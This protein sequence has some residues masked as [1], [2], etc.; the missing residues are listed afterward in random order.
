MLADQ[1]PALVY[2]ASLPAR[3]GQRTQAQ[4]LRVVAGIL[5]KGSQDVDRV[6]WGAL[7]YQHTTLI[8]SKLIEADAP[9]TANKI[10]SALRGTLKEAWRLGL[11]TAEEYQRARDLNPIT[12]VTLPA[13][14]ELSQGEI[15][16]LMTA[17]GND[18]SPAGTRDAAIIALLYG[19]GLRRDEVI[20]LDF[21][22]YDK[23]SG[24]LVV[25]GKRSKE[26]TA[27]LVN[28]AA[29][30]MADWLSLRGSS[31]GAL[32]LA[33]NK[34]G[35]VH[36]AR[37]TSQA[38]YNMLV[39]RA[40]EANVKEFSPHDFRRTF[41]SDLLDK[42]A[43]IATVSKMAGHSDPKTTARYD[44]RPEEAKRKAAGLLHVPYKRKP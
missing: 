12:G 9:A 8:R 27:Y 16:A 34:G 5:S 25:H 36:G 2:L 33:I 38:I 19:A 14:R 26:R 17:C 31:P 35:R 40:G 10:L 4:A 7:R 23:D 28:G 37:M 21:E 13:G 6:D 20:K 24:A 43:D 29:E 39:K 42:G 44:R 3:T 18:E 15:L 11:M 41:I 22:D 32:F 1:N 30:A